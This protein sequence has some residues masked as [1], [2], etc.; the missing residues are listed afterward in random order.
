[1][2]NTCQIIIKSG[3]NAGKKCY[4]VG[5]RC[6][7]KK[8]YV[9]G[10]G[11]KTYHQ[12]SFNRH[13]ESF[14]CT[15]ATDKQI[16][17]LKQKTVDHTPK[18]TPK[19]TPTVKIA[20]KIKPK[21]PLTQKQLPKVQ[22]GETERFTMAEFQDFMMANLDLLNKRIGEMAEQPDINS[23]L[24][25]L[26]DRISEIADK[27]TVINNTY[28]IAIMAPNFYQELETKIGQRETVKLLTSSA[29]TNDPMSILKILYFGGN[30]PNEYPIASK[31]GRYRYL[32]DEG[33]LIETGEDQVGKLVSSRIQKAMS[34]ATG[35]LIRNTM[36]D[37]DKLYDTYD[38]GTIQANI[39]NFPTE[40]VYKELSHITENPAHPFFMDGVSVLCL[41]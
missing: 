14:G 35:K 9:C 33:T 36:H 32:N 24:Q 19:P 15:P 22:E 28:N 18:P 1:M 34:Y 11:F 10:C 7:H 41:E 25:Q 16:E 17:I 38:L 27:P 8:D 21:S 13:V 20:P 6:R 26:N 3:L 31:N 29:I 12:H 23:K 2:P 40:Y 39:Y 5:K 37:T 30:D 4:Q